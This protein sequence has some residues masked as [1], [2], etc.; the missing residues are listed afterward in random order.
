MPTNMLPSCARLVARD[1]TH[2]VEL[3]DVAVLEVLEV[4][5]AYAALVPRGDLTHVVLE[6]AQG[7]HGR[8]GNDHAVAEQ[9]DLLPARRLAFLHVAACDGADLRDLERRP[10]LR[11]SGDLLG[12]DGLEHA[13]ERG[14]DVLDQLVDDLVRTDLD[15]ALLRLRARLSVRPNV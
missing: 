14:L 10:H 2:F 7:R 9:P 3:Q 4:L 5:E 12:E 6:A 1:F 13:F 11:A 8:V 15:A